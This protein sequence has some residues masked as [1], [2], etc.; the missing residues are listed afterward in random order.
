MVVMARIATTIKA[1]RQQVRSGLIL[2]KG[3][4]WGLYKLVRLRTLK[5]HTRHFSL[6]ARPTKLSYC[7]HLNLKPDVQISSLVLSISMC[8][9]VLL[10]SK[11]Q[12]HKES[13]FT[14]LA[15]TSSCL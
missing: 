9:A 1:L 7:N 10:E 2:T 12:K 5:V 4:K 11:V 6:K 13:T 3:C 14:D 8:R 15:I